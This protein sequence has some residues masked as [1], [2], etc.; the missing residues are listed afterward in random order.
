MA[1]AW[2]AAGFPVARFI[3]SSVCRVS[4][5]IVDGSDGDKEE[6]VEP[7]PVLSGDLA[8]FIP[9]VCLKHPPQTRLGGDVE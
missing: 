6:F 2:A 4:A 8:A 5:C 9:G 7:V 3:A 1:S